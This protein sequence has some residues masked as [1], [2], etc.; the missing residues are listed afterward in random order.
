MVV[1]MTRDSKRNIE[2]RIEELETDTSRDSHGPAI[3]YEHP[4]TGEWIDMAGQAVDPDTR[5][6]MVI[7]PSDEEI[8]RRLEGDNDTK[9]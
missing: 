9:D 4:K 6:L 2:R 5:P 8:K 1:Y 7:V 3:V